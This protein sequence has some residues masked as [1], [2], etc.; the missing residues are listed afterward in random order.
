M[1]SLGLLGDVHA[2]ASRLE[3]SLSWLGKQGPLDGILLVGDIAGG[4][5]MSWYRETFRAK[6]FVAKAAKEIM[7]GGLE[8]LNF[9]YEPHSLPWAP[10]GLGQNL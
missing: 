6:T 4:W 3:R 7:D 10:G 2:H 1:P 5:N 9:D 8:G